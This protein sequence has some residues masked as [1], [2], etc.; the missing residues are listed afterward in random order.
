MDI[1]SFGFGYHS[2]VIPYLRDIIG[3]VFQE[4]LYLVGG[5]T[6]ERETLFGEVT[7]DGPLNLCCQCV[8]LFRLFYPCVPHHQLQG[9]GSKVENNQIPPRY[10]VFG[11][12]CLSADVEADAA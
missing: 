1:R 5:V 4:A 2:E 3:E 8:S 9:Q 10:R 11:I 6:R 12:K 7:F